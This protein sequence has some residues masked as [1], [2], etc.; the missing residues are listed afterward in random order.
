M[1]QT[2]QNKLKSYSALAGAIAA[3][4]AANAQIIYT[5]VAPDVTVNTSGMGIQIDLD[6]GGVV[7]FTLGFASGVTTSSYAYNQV[8][9][10]VPQN[11][12]NAI[13]QNGSVGAAPAYPLN[14]AHAINDVIG[15][16]L[17]WATDTAQFAARVYPASTSYNFGNWVGATDKYFGF[18]FLLGTNTHYGWARVDVGG[19]AELFTLKDY[20]YESTPNLPILA[21]AMPVAT[22]IS[23]HGLTGNV[24]IFSTEKNI[25]VNMNN[26]EATGII[27]VSNVLGQVISTSS[28]SDQSTVINLESAITGIYFVTVSQSK[29]KFTQ[30]VIIK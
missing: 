2:L 11:G 18:R 26:A 25:V 30:K 17:T 6:N 21:G 9:T 4:G 19:S 5:D 24:K 29:E 1:K 3:T 14:A 23:E 27:T 22:S 12:I 8:I 20:A 16:T 7:D 15:T 10:N 13:S 28:I